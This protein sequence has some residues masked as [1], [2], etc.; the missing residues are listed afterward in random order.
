MFKFLSLKDKST[1]LALRTILYGNFVL[2]AL[3]C[4]IAVSGTEE[5]KHAMKTVGVDA[6]PSVQAA[7]NI[8]NAILQ[9]HSD[10]ANELIG[11]PGANYAS[12]KDYEDWRVTLN[13]EL[14]SAAKNITYAAEDDAVDSLQQSLD[15]FKETVVAARLYH[16]R[17]DAAYLASFRKAEE[18]L[19]TK[20]LPAADQLDKANSD[21][22]ES[23][24]KHQSETSWVSLLLLLASGGGLV[25][26]N[27]RGWWYVRNKTKRRF[28]IPS[29]ASIALAGLFTLWMGFHFFMESRELHA[30][31]EDA[32]DSIVA[33][34][35][36]ESLALSGN[37]AESAWLL[38]DPL[39]VQYEKAFKTDSAGVLTLSNG[40]TVNA[41]EA[42]AK[43]EQTADKSSASGAI[44]DE[45]RNITFKGER[46]SAIEM[47][48]WWGAYVAID[49]Q[50]R[51]LEKQ[52]KHDEAVAL[53]TGEDEGQSN[54][55]FE[56]FQDGLHA[57]LDINK[58]HFQE[59]VKSGTDRIG[60]M[61]G[62][63]VVISILVALC[64]LFGLRPH[65]KRYGL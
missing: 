21:V 17:H 19:R 48:H 30:V 16:E 47:L 34:L 59:D 5:H 20:A 27:L 31:K 39:K 8:K 35:K 64:M 37:A 26:W 58:K 33:L 12:V 9:M 40:Q 42:A 22:L 10:V 43:K 52:G 23:V 13:D 50:I 57:T 44:A 15:E 7:Y 41:M 32:H 45:L 11:K 3:F 60:L 25:L 18:I 46:E 56:K 51:N 2:A 55:A 6:A 28:S 49:G 4:L 36:G 61:A 29:L 14:K 62:G 63:T 38:D 54:Y 24:Y 53:C 65:M 1:P